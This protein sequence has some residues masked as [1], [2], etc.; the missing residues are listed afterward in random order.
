MLNVL[1]WLEALLAVGAH[2]R[3]ARQLHVN[4][5]VRQCLAD[6]PNNL[7]SE[8]AT[9]IFSVLTMSEESVS[10]GMALG[11]RHCHRHCLVEAT[12]EFR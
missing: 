8:I 6:T 10:C 9:N 5:A 12:G 7:P 3:P 2:V 1:A 11:L 4:A